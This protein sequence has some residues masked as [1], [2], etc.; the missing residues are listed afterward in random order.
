MYRPGM[1]LKNK[2]RKPTS[3]FVVIDVYYRK[4]KDGMVAQRTIGLHINDEINVFVES[5]DDGVRHIPEP[6]DW[7]SRSVHKSYPY[8]MWEP[9]IEPE[10]THQ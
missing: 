5:T 10:E 6:V 1:I 8:I 4:Y 9:E 3:T 7:D 2:A